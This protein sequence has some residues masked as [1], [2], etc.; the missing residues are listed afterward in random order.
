M[1]IILTKKAIMSLK[2]ILKI[3]YTHLILFNDFV[4]MI[5]SFDNEKRY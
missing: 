1:S 2:N 4:D 5:R 3:Y